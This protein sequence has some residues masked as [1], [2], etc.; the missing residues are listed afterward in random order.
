MLANLL[1][2]AASAQTARQWRQ[3]SRWED[4]DEARPRGDA[5]MRREMLYAHNRARDAIGV[6][7]LAWDAA[8]AQ[9]ADRYAYELTRTRTFRHSSKAQRSS[10]QGEN[11][12]MGTLDAFTYA[13]MAASWMDERRFYRAAAFP[14]ISTTGQWADVGHYTQ[15]VWRSTT[16]VGCAL[17][18]NERDEYLVCRYSPP[19]NVFGR[20]V[21]DD[22]PRQ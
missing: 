4:A 14:N 8:L 13:E 11:L 20:T 5:L 17:R 18:A 7:P 9:D 1:N 15:A 10:P 19:G 21:M 3:Q 2:G 12:W 6:P 22:Q 16:H